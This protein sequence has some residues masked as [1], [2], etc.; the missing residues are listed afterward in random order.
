MSVSSLSKIENGIIKPKDEHFLKL[1]KRLG[2]KA[3]PVYFNDNGHYLLSKAFRAFYDKN[4]AELYNLEK[5]TI[6][7]QNTFLEE[8][9]NLM[10]YTE[11]QNHNAVDKLG[12]K[13]E[14]NLNSMTGLMRQIYVLLMAINAYDRKK[15]T[16]TVELLKTSIDGAKTLALLAPLE[17]SYLFMAMSALHYNTDH[18]HHYIEATHGFNKHPQKY[19]SNELVLIYTLSLSKNYPDKARDYIQYINPEDLTES[20]LGLY[21]E[22]YIRSNKEEITYWDAFSILSHIVSLKESKEKYRALRTLYFQTSLDRIQAY[23]IDYFKG[24]EDQGKLEF[25]PIRVDM[26]SDDEAKKDLIKEIA[27]PLAFESQDVSLLL[28]Y[29]EKIV[30]ITKGSSRYKEALAFNKKI[31]KYLNKLNPQL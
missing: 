6:V 28:D 5:E 23:I 18:I 27:V 20:Q 17:N 24:Q 3:N 4:L 31:A 13:L 29:K 22:S 15:Y 26:T 14:N 12:K 16:D 10:I 19:R 9:I 7:L 8:L 25:V 11:T 2:I 30:S 21:Y 1:S